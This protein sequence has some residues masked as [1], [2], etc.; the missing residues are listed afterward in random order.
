MTLTDYQQGLI[1]LLVSTFE[2]SACVV[3]SGRTGFGKRT[4]VEAA[5]HK[6][7]LDFL[8]VAIDAPARAVCRTLLGHENLAFPVCNERGLLAQE[9]ACIFLSGAEY[10]NPELLPV[11]REIFRARSHRGL[12]AE[13]HGQVITISLCTDAHKPVLRDTD[14][15]VMTTPSVRFP[16]R[17]DSRDLFQVSTSILA[18]MD[19]DMNVV[20]DDFKNVRLPREGLA[21]LRK[22]VIG[23]VASHGRIDRDVLMAAISADVVPFVERICYRGNYIKG[24]E[25]LEWTKQFD[26]TTR[27]IIDHLVRIMVERKYVMSERDF[28]Q[29]VNDI[30]SRSGIPK[31]HQV[32]LCEWQRFGKSGPVMAHRV[33]ERGNW[34]A[35]AISLNLEDDPSVWSKAISGKNLPVVLA[36]DFVGTGDSIFVAEP[37]IR[38]LLETCPSTTVHILLVAGFADGIQRLHCL[39]LE[40]GERVK[41]VVGRLLYNSDTCFHE[42]SDILQLDERR[43]LGNFCDELGRRVKTKISRGYGNLG[44]LFAFPESIPNT[45]LPIFWYDSK[46]NIWLPLLAASM[47]EA[48]DGKP[49]F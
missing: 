16:D 5:S 38:L 20:E 48:H 31:G 10:L 36:D 22:W 45:T 3:I 12:G 39:E 2:W 8:S 33:K 15:F 44:A 27:P 6:L 35:R 42:S 29:I 18:E 26:P 23:A 37:R 25:Y 7:G 41:I 21:S 49:N 13:P 43:V 14:Q 4:I 11:F 34:G 32:V 46:P 40:Y 28:H 30:V 17:L 47:I 19:V 1:K 24:Y 9:G